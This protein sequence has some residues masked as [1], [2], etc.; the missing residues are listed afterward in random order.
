M[1]TKMLLIAM[2]FASF[3]LE[4]QQQAFKYQAVARD[5]QGHAI[6]NQDITM[7]FTIY[8]DD[9]QQKVVYVESHTTKT[10]AQGL[11]Y[12]NIGEGTPQTGTFDAITWEGFDY[13][14][15]VESDFE[16]GTNYQDYGVFRLL[17]VP[18]AFH[19]ET[20]TNKDDAD[21][22]PSNEIQTLTKNGQTITLSRNGGSFTDEV[23][24]ADADPNN[25]LQMLSVNG[26]Q[27]TISGGNTVNLPSGGGGGSG[28]DDPNNEVQDLSSSKNG[29]EIDLN[30]SLGGTGTK[31]DISD[32]DADP[33]NEIQDI[34]S[35]RQGNVVTLGL[36]GSNQTSFEVQD[37]DAD[38]QNEV[39]SLMRNGNMITL[40]LNGG[41]VVDQ[42]DD[43]DSDPQNEIQDIK[44][45]GTKLSIEKG[46]EVDLKDAGHW[47]YNSNTQTLEYLEDQLVRVKKLTLN[48]DNSDVQITNQFGSSTMLSTSFYLTQT[49]SG[50]TSNIIP[51]TIDLTKSGNRGSLNSDN[52]NVYESGTGAEVW[53]NTGEMRFSN[54]HDGYRKAKYGD[55]EA[56][57]A[58]HNSKDTININENRVEFNSNDQSEAIYSK[59]SLYISNYNIQDALGQAKLTYQR[60]QMGLNSR[61]MDLDAGEMKM[62]SYEIP[63]DQQYFKHSADSLEFRNGSNDG[64]TLF[65]RSRMDQ[66]SINFID[67][68]SE[69]LGCFSSSE[70]C[71]NSSEGDATLN[72]SGL[73]ITQKLT[74]QDEWNRVALLPGGLQLTNDAK[75]DNV[76]LGDN[77]DKAGILQLNNG[78]GLGRIASLGANPNGFLPTE[79][80]NLQLYFRD[81][82]EPMVW[83]DG[84]NGYGEFCLF[85]KNQ[86]CFFE[87]NASGAF[88]PGAYMA[89]SDSIGEDRIKAYMQTVPGFIGQDYTKGVVE[90][91]GDVLGEVVASNFHDTLFSSMNNLGVQ[92]EGT[93]AVNKSR[94]IRDE[95]FNGIDYSIFMQTGTWDEG[96]LLARGSEGTINVEITTSAEVDQ[97]FNA[98][99]GAVYV[100]DDED[101]RRAGMEVRQLDGLGV[102]WADVKNFRMDHPEDASKEIV[103][104]SLEGPEAAAYSR[105][106]SQLE[107]GK[108]FVQ[109]PKHFQLVS[110]PETMTIQLTPLYA[111]TIGLAVIEKTKDGFWVQERMEGQ[112]SFEFDW[113]ATCVR[114]GYE[115]F[116][117]IRK[118]K[119]IKK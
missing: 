112:G 84:G 53:V 90:V 59:D 58:N 39:Q 69:N 76:F 47:K 61:F 104:A 25:E 56:E 110:N 102:V 65:A 32:Q 18:Y 88:H 55:S 94:Q 19:A 119:M 99:Y 12:I 105:G 64:T 81:S 46:S 72:S 107:K 74:P 20:V 49:P 83:L 70:L 60:F 16:G 113:Q 37:S 67:G 57:I 92:T 118:K 48:E 31:I 97:G 93:V 30:I 42:V 36:S 95:I 21:A 75:W 22:D 51:A 11:F 82:E 85:N 2:I 98:D 79:G 40:S 43:S 29:N 62:E 6:V 50:A 41:S 103:Y 109:F 27:L 8:M 45:D 87:L 15:N 106:T 34:T 77:S 52:M 108:T 63:E 117:V 1:K 114:K 23:D 10:S 17:T 35:D 100:Y 4:A 14:I 89:L 101:V 7:R 73:L 91:E 66:Y 5:D 86:N 68:F 3:I 96:L 28:D 9:V 78:T 38:P 33:M 80:G 111:N 26:N 116:E 44:L 71:L 24:D 13:A 115:D 54:I